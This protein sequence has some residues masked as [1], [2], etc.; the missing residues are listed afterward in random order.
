MQLKLNEIRQALGVTAEGDA[1]AAAGELLATGYSIDSR[2]LEAGDLF[3]AVKG[4]RFDGHS[5]VAGAMERGA[6]GA[7]VARARA[8]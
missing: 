8:G 5:F 1:A 2:T 4:E 3:F 6:V 7:V